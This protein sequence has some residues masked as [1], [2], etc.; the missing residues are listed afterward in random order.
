MGGRRVLSIRSLRL[1]TRGR[2]SRRGREWPPPKPAPLFHGTGRRHTRRA[3]PRRESPNAWPMSHRRRGTC[4]HHAL[5]ANRSCFCRATVGEN[6]AMAINHDQNFK[7]LIL[8]YPHDALALFAPEEAPWPEERARIVPV[9]QERLVTGWRETGRALLVEWPD[10]RRKSV[11]FVVEEETD[12]PAGSLP[13]GW[14]TTASPF[15]AARHRAHRARRG[16]APLREVDA[17]VV[18]AGIRTP[19][20]SRVRVGVGWTGFPWTGGGTAATSWRG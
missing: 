7:N 14:R 2:A 16:L 20:V 19:P 6:A 10:G 18:G 8:D 13:T 9:R 17:G 5:A 1:E 3:R 11:A 15:R 4:L 12:P